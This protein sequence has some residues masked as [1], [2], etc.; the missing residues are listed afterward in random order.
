MYHVNK[1]ALFITLFLHNPDDPNAHANIL[2]ESV[3]LVV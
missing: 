2:A 1:L 3:F